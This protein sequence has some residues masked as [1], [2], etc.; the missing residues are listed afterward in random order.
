MLAAVF[1]LPYALHHRTYSFDLSSVPPYSGTPYVELNGNEP[2]FTAEERKSEPFVSY[3]ELDGLGRCGPAFGCLSYE[4]MPTEDREPISSVK[5]S[6]W[7]NKKYDFIEKDY[8]YNR[9]HLIAFMLA[10]ENANPKNLITGTRYLNVEGMLPFETTVVRYI[11]LTHDRVLYRVTPVFEGTNLV[12]SGVEME[13]LSLG[14]N[15]ENI[16]FH[17]YVYNVQPGV[18]I[19]YKT[20]DSWVSPD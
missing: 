14:D 11:E 9:C 5:P 12:C 2:F 6:G 3:S 8:L 16:R 17:V 4:A 7:I 10:G 13:A 15:G 19:N 20:G 1:A 18:E